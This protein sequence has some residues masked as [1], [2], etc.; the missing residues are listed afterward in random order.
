MDNAPDPRWVAI[1]NR[2]KTA[3]GQ[4]VY[5]VKTTGVYCRPSCSSRQAKVENIEFYADND[6]AERAGYRPCKRCRPTQLSQAQ[7]HAEKISQ[8]CRL[9]E[10]A[11]TPFT[12]DALATELNLSAFHFHRL[13]K[14]ITGLTP[15]AYA[16]ATRSARI[17]QQLVEK[18]SVT[19]AIFEAGYN[20]N[21]RFYEQ[22]NQLLGMTPTRYRQGGRDTALH[23]AVG[24]SSLGAILMAKSELGICAILLGDDPALLVQQL[25]DK[26]PQAELIGGDA[27]FE[28]WFAQVVGLVEA[29]QLGLDLPLDIRGTAF[30]QRV[31]QA[32][33][34]IPAGDTASYADIA[35]KIGAP[36]AVRA[37]AGACA[38]NMLAVAIPCH[39]VIRQDG[40]LSGYRWGI[41]RKKRLL[42]KEQQEAETRDQPD[43]A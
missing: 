12:L 5:A 37:V 7:Q 34:E 4:F 9:I 1:V 36:K 6:A 40:A 22:S 16:S 14:S 26:F 30:Q 20:S 24:E 18:G 29:P 33:R 31:W 28:Q 15:K 11:E 35:A 21:G 23:F 13:F 42:E 10:Q 19:D 38:A 3:D 39:R 43:P 32:L 25:Q 41:E 17:R 2:D 27:E 8:A